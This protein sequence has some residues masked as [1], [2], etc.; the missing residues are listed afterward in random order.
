MIDIKKTKPY[1]DMVELH[2]NNQG[3][4][5]TT[6]AEWISVKDR[7]PENGK[8]VLLYSESGGVAEGALSMGFFRQW[9]W[10]CKLDDVTHW[11]PLPSPPESDKC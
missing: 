7:L 4:D 5:M 1:T 11:I 3:R 10:N 2:N 8:C 6:S 9:R